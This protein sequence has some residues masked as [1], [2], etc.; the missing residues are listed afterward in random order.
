MSWP[1]LLE[2]ALTESDLTRTAR[3]YVQRG[4]DLLLAR[5]R[6]GAGGYEIVSAYTGMMD[7]LIRYLFEVASQD[8]IR[9]YPSLSPR[10]T[11]IAQGGYGRGELNPRSDID[12]LFLHSWKVTP[13]VESVAEKVLYALWDSGIQVGHAIRSIAESVRL[14]NKDM[15]VK[16]AMID[17]RYLSGDRHLYEDFER[18][19]QEQFLKWNGDRFARKKLEENRLR[20]QRY[21][22]SVYLLEPDIKEGEGGLRDIHTALWICKVKWKVKDLDELDRRGVLSP[23]DLSELRSSQDFIWRVRNELHFASGKHQDQLTFGEQ[24]RVAVALG[25]KDDGAVRGVEVF[26]RAYYLH[27]SQISRMASLIIHRAMESDGASQLGGR[28][29]GRKIREGV[30]ISRGVLRISNPAILAEQPENLVSIFADLQ[31]H[32]AEMGHETREVI[33]EHL[34]LIDDRFRRSVRANAGFLQI[35]KGR[36]R[37][38]ETLLEMHRCGVLDAF[39]PEFGQLRCMVLHD[40]YHIYTVDQHSLKAVQEFERLKAGEFKDSLPLLTQL[41][42]EVDKVEVLILSILFHDIGKGRGGG[43]SEIGS[44]IARTVARRLRL[45]VDDRVLLA[46]LVRHHLILSH[47]AFRRDVDDENMVVDLAYSVGSVSNLKMLY[48][49]TYADTKA[50]GPEVWN[51]WKGSL[52]ED[53]YVRTLRILEEL[54]KG[55]FRRGDSRAKVRRIQA[56]LRR[57]LRHFL[58]SMP[59]RYFLTTP[60]EEIPFHFRLIEQ[61]SDQPFLSSVRH[62]PESEYSEMVICAKDRPGL[63]A[64]ITGVFAAMGL[65]ILSARI[66]TRKDGLILDVF[67]ISHSGK[68]EVVM[69]AER[70][71]RVQATLE[72]VLTGAVDIARLVQESGRPLLFKRQ[73]PRVPT[74]VRMDNGASEDFTILEVYTQDRIGVLFTITYALHQLGVSIHLAKISTN[75]DQVA[76]VFYVTDE[77]GKKIQDKKRL[78]TIRQTLYQCLRLDDERIAQSAH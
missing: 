47:T 21:G 53:L 18:A 34:G 74:V 13:F 38:Y 1:S 57:R 59:D 5:H 39:V 58:D 9:R 44:R 62:F 68:P 66:T 25:F 51:N 56:R 10:C 50:V 19:V 26:M 41:A 45:N 3:A 69:E 55:E 46:F 73:A 7:H 64:C 54:E 31:R 32:K 29:P 16:T 63:F 23:R 75:V 76:D 28:S 2:Q 70:W 40:L 71:A 43:H 15:K 72:R 36:D 22:G 12:L 6:A 42:R 8:Y 65:D 24:E 35:L 49:L 77:K 27:A 37:V 61:F 11:L 52:L 78:E 60:E 33:R 17:A 67:R 4:Q 48:V 30:R 14:G 20:H